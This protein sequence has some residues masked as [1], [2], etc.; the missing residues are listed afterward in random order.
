MPTNFVFNNVG[1][2]D[3]YTPDFSFSPAGITYK[4]ILKG[5]LD[6]RCVW[7]DFGANLYQGKLYLASES[8]LNIIDLKTNTIY[9]YYSKNDIGRANEVLIDDIIVDINVTD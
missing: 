1:K 4:Y 8:S 6:F 2:G 7:A 3:P 5:P 9:D